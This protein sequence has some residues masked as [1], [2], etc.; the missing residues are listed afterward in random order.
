MRHLS[1][2]VSNTN[3]RSSSGVVM[4]SGSFFSG[5]LASTQP[6]GM[7]RERHANCHSPLRPNE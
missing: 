7:L 6:R 5:D 2:C 4:N 3:R 1:F